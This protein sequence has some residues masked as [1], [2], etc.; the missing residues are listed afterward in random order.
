[1]VIIACMFFLNINI[2]G[3]IYIPV[4]GDYDDVLYKDT[5]DVS[6]HGWFEKN[7]KIYYRQKDGKIFDRIGLQRIEGHYYFLEKDYSRFSGVKC[8]DGKYYLFAYNGQNY[9]KNGWY[10]IRGKKYYFFK[11]HSIAVGL[12]RIDGHIY[13]FDE[14]GV[15]Q[16]N[17]RT[18][19][20]GDRYY[21]TNSSG[22]IMKSSE[23]QKK[24]R[25]ATL[26]YIEKHSGKNQTNYEK[27]HS[28][29]IY[30]DIHFRL[31][32]RPWSYYNFEDPEWPYVFALDMF[33]HSLRGNCFNFSSCMACIAKELG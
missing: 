23:V 17:Q 8:I 11:D 24:C 28:C 26:E 33:E 16:K 31:I 22:I 30:M 15:L 32:P 25:D 6:N 29:F 9:R 12:K 7:G 14:K 1:M 27:L 5:L 19:E 4:N 10:E 20:Y 3:D 2:A 21:K 13:Y 18:F